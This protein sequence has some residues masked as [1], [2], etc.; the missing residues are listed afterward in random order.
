MSS[1]VDGNKVA[2]L[3]CLRI[4]RLPIWRK[5]RVLP[6]AMSLWQTILPMQSE[7]PAA[8]FAAERPLVLQSL[9]LFTLGSFQAA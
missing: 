1:L 6:A 9:T 3:A 2:I 7:S 4:L 5:W 8:A